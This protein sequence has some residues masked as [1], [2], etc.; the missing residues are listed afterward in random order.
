MRGCELAEAVVV[1]DCLVSAH[2]GASALD[3]AIEATIGKIGRFGGTDSTSYLEAYKSKMQMR[4]IPKDRRLAGFPRV[5]TPHIHTEM[6]AIQVGCH[7][8]A[9]FAEDVLERYTMMIRSS[10]Q[11]R[12]L[13]TGSTAPT[14]VRMLLRSSRS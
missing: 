5:V 3:R 9:E 6:V 1:V 10:Y 2:E 12:I 11:E 8:W 7:D 13:W 4:N 14:R